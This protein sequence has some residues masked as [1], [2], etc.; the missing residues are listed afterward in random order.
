MSVRPGLGCLAAASS[1]SFARWA[2]I[3][4]TTAPAG[5][6][7]PAGDIT[8]LLE[9]D[10]SYQVLVTVMDTVRSFPTVQNLE[11]VQGELFPVISLG[12]TPPG[13]DIAQSG[14]REGGKS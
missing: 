6:S 10:T 14:A 8:V 12:D 7:S 11:V 13:R 9:R 2:A 1:S 4:S 5:R 3:D